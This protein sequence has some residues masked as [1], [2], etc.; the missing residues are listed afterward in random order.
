MRILAAVGCDFTADSSSFWSLSFT[1]WKR[2][3]CPPCWVPERLP[4]DNM[5]TTPGTAAIKDV[6]LETPQR[7]RGFLRDV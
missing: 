3:E 5:W 2:G 4:S 7:P 6:M 1:I